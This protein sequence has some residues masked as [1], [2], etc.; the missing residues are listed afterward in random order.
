MEKAAK[1]IAVTTLALM[2]AAC[3]SAEEETK[4]DEKNGVTNVAPTPETLFVTADNVL[5]TTAVPAGD[6]PTVSF[7]VG[8]EKRTYFRITIE[9]SSLK[10]GY[11]IEKKNGQNVTDHSYVS[12]RATS[13]ET[14]FHET[15]M[16]PTSFSF[17][18]LSLNPTQVVIEVSGRLVQ[19]T[20]GQNIVLERSTLK[21]EGD[22]LKT[23]FAEE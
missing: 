7:S 14:D 8:P 20:T 19:R 9:R 3:G 11:A 15:D 4:P 1:F 10:A 12:V 17:K 16:P 21:I 23:L 22:Q 18:I 13:D 6:P 5:G 2:L